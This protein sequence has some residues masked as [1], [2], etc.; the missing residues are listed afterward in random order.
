MWRARSSTSD[1]RSRERPVDG[2]ALPDR[3]LLVAD[4]GEQRDA[5]S[6][7]RVVELDHSLPGGRS[8]APRR[9]VSRSPCAADDELDRRPGERRGR[10]GQSPVS[11][12]S[13]ARRPPSS[14]LQ[15]LGHAAR[16]GPAV[17]LRVRADELAP[18]L[19]REERV[20][21]RRLLDAGELRPGQIETEPLLE[22]VVER[23]QA[24][25]AERE[26]R[27][28]IRPGTRDRAR[29]GRPSSGAVRTVAS[30]P[31][32]SS[33][34]R[35]SAICSTP[36]DDGSSHWR[37]SSATTTGPCSAST[38]ST[39]STASPIAC[40]SGR[41]LAGLGQQERDLE[42]PPPRRRERGR[43]PPRARR[44]AGPRARRTRATPRPRRSGRSGRGRSA[45]SASSTPASHRIVLPIPGSPE[46][47]SA[48]G[49]SST[50]PR[51]ASIEP[52][53]SSRPMTSAHH[54][55]GHCG[56]PE[57]QLSSIA[58]PPSSAAQC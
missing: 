46:R 54:R 6:E 27:E 49:P 52:S 31:T 56:R 36:A 45:R 11:V 5:R 19:E 12:G 35:R 50:R 47:T 55:L 53:S 2:A 26:P 51:N 25:R 48:P 30:R 32:R 10:R 8:R 42:R 9:R 28:P 40:G 23:R 16:L 41:R 15:A 18:E 4:R 29:T 3:R 44:R 20:A 38:R 22:Q 34:R 1:D 58:A 17:G 57:P 7:A 39:S 33:R 37:S 14:S 13:R 43:R 24:E 21:R